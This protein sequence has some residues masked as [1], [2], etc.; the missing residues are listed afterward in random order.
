MPRMTSADYS[1]LLCRQEARKPKPVSAYEEKKCQREAE[2]HEQISSECKRRGW[3]TIHSRMDKKAT[4]A[5]GTPDF[6]IFPNGSCAFSVECKTDI[7][8][9]STAQLGASAWLRKL[10]HQYFVVRSFQEFL[11]LPTVTN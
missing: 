6:V 7:G 3:Y 4:T 11:G 9:L 10:G 2:L 5:V 1:A 8:K